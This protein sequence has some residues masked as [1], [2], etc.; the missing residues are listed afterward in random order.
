[1]DGGESQLL[2]DRKFHIYRVA[3]YECGPDID[4]ASDAI[5]LSAQPGEPPDRHRRLHHAVAAGSACG[6]GGGS[7]IGGPVRARTILPPR[8]CR[9]PATL[10]AT[11]RVL[12]VSSGAIA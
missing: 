5:G 10:V 2:Q 6:P 8:V 9:P 1:M 4:R 12:S 3:R 7:R 11:Q